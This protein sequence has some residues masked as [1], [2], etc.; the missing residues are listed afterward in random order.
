MRPLTTSQHDKH[1]FVT[2]LGV[3]CLLILFLNRKKDPV[4]IFGNP[5]VFSFLKWSWDNPKSG[6][7]F[8]CRTVA[9]D[10]PT[11]GREKS[12]GLPLLLTHL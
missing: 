1:L 2:F 4:F 9:E 5:E 6:V 10:Y 3:S 11:G 8:K 12:L 7:S